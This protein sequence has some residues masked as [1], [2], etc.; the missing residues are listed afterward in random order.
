MLLFGLWDPSKW[1]EVE[2]MMNHQRGWSEILHK[3][4]SGQKSHVVVFFFFPP[5]DL[6]APS[7]VAVIH[8][9]GFCF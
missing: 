1:E 9:D 4:F 7:L 5:G 6:L 2:E 8:K 3:P